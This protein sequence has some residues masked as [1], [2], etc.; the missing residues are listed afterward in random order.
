[1][2][3][4]LTAVYQQFFCAGNLITTRH[5]LTAAHCMQEKNVAR[6]L[7]PDDI[8]VLLGRYNLKLIGERGSEF[9]DVSR[10][11]VHPDWKNYSVK[12]DADL[13]LV[14]LDQEIVFSRFIQPVC[15]TDDPEIS[16]CDHG[17]AVLCSSQLKTIAP[18]TDF[19][20]FSRLAG[21]KVKA[22]K[23]TRQFH[24]KLHSRLSTI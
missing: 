2:A 8:I 20:V 5:V 6:Q 4:L 7:Q 3:A 12:Y 24:V 21:E 18:L 23:C 16:D 9:R 10:I 1:M 22:T 19:H 11:F 14:V 15:M 17:F 13:A